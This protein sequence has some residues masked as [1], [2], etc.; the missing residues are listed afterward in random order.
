MLDCQTA[1]EKA[2]SGY[3][4]DCCKLGFTVKPSHNWSDNNRDQRNAKA[5]SQ[6][7]PKQCADLIRGDFRSLN[8]RCRKTQIFI[9]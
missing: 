4:R 7:D 2:K 8:R 3:R 6:V 9:R 1:N 5:Q